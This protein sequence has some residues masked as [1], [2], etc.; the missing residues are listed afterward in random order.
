MS[1][2]FSETG[3]RGTESRQKPVEMSDFCLPDTLKP[4]LAA[5]KVEQNSEK[6]KKFLR[7]QLQIDLLRSAFRLIQ[8][9]NVTF[10]QFLLYGII[11][12]RGDCFAQI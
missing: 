5:S 10:F 11:F 9:R 4:A 2:R 1:T 12:T 8:A 7:I 3:S 6:L